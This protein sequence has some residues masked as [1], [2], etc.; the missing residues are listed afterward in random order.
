MD[1]FRFPGEN[2]D[3]R[4]LHLGTKMVLVDGNSLMHR[5]FHALPLLDDGAGVY[6]NAVFGFLSMLLKVLKDEQPQYLAVAFDLHEPTFRHEEYQAYKAG[7]PATPEELRPQ[8]PLLHELLDAMNICQVSLS[9]Y[10]ADD[11]LGTLSKKCEQEGVESLLVTGDRDAFQLA[12]PLTAILY[13]KRGITDTERVTPGY[14]MEKYALTPLQMIDLKGLM[15]DNSDNIPGIPGVGE[16]TALKLLAQYGTLENVLEQ[17]ARE[18]KGKLREKLEQYGQQARFCKKIATI[19]RDAP[20]PFE[21]NNYRIHDMA[22]GLEALERYKLK[23]LAQRLHQLPAGMLGVEAAVQDVPPAENEAWSQIAVLEDLA[24]IERWAADQDAGA[25]LALSPLEASCAL[26][27]GAQ[28]LIPLGGGDLIS[29][30]LSDRDFLQGIAPLLAGQGEKVVCSVKRLLDL[31]PQGAALNGPVFD[32]MLAAYALNPQEKSYALPAL[33]EQADLP[34]DQG[35]TQAARLWAL[36]DRQNRQLSEDGLWD[37]YSRIELPLAYALRDMEQV[38]FLVDEGELRAL[39]E[40]YTARIAKDRDEIYRL[41]GEEFNL[42]SPKQLGDIL[43]GKLGIEGAKKTGKGW[44]T[45]A[46]I[47]ESVAD[48][49][50]IV[51]LVLDYRRNF[52]LNSTYIEAL[53][54]LKGPDGR[55]H[56]Q[57]DQTATATGRISSNEPNLQNIPVRTEEGRQIRRAFV[58]GP[59]R[60]LVDADYSQI[61]LRVLAHMSGDETLCEAFRLGQDIHRRTAAEVYAVPIDQVTGPMRSAAKA[62]NFGII[63]GISDFGLARNIGVSRKEAASFIERYF[64]RYPGVKR[65]MDEQ[66][67]LGKAQGY[68]TTLFGRRRYLNELSSSNYNLRS[69]GE[70][71]AMNSPI[72][73]TA[74]D[75]IKISMIRVDQSL[76]NAGLRARLILQV[77]DELIV[78]APEDEKEQAAQLLREA[79]EGAAQLRVPLMVD[80]STGRN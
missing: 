31:M 6:T 69:F 20:V 42:N 72:Q 43:F 21:L 76:K 55:I 58:A 11:M 12:G 80:L 78:E 67:A 22:Q 15:G 14:L 9:R 24:A 13:T 60:V 18:Q 5:A 68:V 56:T 54:R 19:Q 52:K 32:V 27:Q 65:F 28:A 37:L 26:R 64:A 30:G 34:R 38:G 66:V 44:S 79:M 33:L 48:Q 70:R 1:R 16:K 46:D 8:F 74:A 7:R 57:F 23:S 50:E 25:G 61:E 49:H 62:V 53:L 29:P 73:G 40:M 36:R 3:G 35:H 39:G 47:L 71:A 4:G 2:A 75:I 41:A 51:P 63:Y 10:E 77:H 17:G 59:G 45:T